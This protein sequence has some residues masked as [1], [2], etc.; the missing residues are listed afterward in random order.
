MLTNE[1]ITE[2]AADPDTAVRPYANEDA[3]WQA[4]LARDPAADGVFYYAVRSTGIYCR[5]T[6]P[7][8]RPRRDR[9]AFFDLPAD[10]ERAGFRPCRRCHPNEVTGQQQV[11]ARVQELLEEADDNARIPTLA[12]LGASV[13]LSPFH[14]QRVFKRATGLSPRQYAAARRG[15]RLK[16]QLRR[17]ASVTQALYDA[18]YGS[19]RALYAAVDKELAMSPSSYKRGGAGEHIAYA[20]ADS[21]LGRMLVAATERGV[22]ALRFGDDASLE[23]ELRAEFPQAEL[24]RDP[25]A[26]AAYVRA[27]VAHLEGRQPT[28][29]V[30]TD[31][32]GSAFQQRVWAAL[33]QI[34]YGQTRS[35]AQLA[36]MIGDP[37]AVRAVAHA[38]AT[39]PVALVVP[40]HRV[41]RTGGALG[42]YRWGLDRKRA[43]LEREREAAHSRLV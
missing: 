39:N 12:A 8:R 23:K 41:V 29:E 33:R 13:G 16:A 17:G 10:A 22:C 42:G 6:C 38:C 35:Y 40:C 5:P 14:L 21:P 26:V 31:A 1:L 28:L 4:V 2:R 20:L 37:S 7:A 30:P 32:R 15:A 24:V 3:R 25:A 43:L 34:P 11:V 19:S 18:G 36:Q 27:A 9:V